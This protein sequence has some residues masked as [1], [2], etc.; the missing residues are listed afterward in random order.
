[1]L[2]NIEKI[3]DFV[4]ACSFKS[5]VIQNI[6]STGDSTAVHNSGDSEDQEYDNYFEQIFAAN[7]NVRVDITLVY[8][9]RKRIYCCFGFLATAYQYHVPQCDDPK[10]VL[11]AI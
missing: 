6:D 11:I 5:G 10:E 1:M 7:G 8:Q 4:K 3:C 9:N 2:I